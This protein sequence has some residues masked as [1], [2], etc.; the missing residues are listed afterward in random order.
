MKRFLIAAAIMVVIAILMMIAS[1]LQT[2]E[3]ANFNP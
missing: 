2:A 1:T 3:S